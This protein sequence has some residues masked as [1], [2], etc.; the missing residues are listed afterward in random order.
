ME[1]SPGGDMQ[2]TSGVFLIA[3]GLVAWLYDERLR[4]LKAWDRPRWTL[5][6][7]TRLAFS[8]LRRIAVVAGWLLLLRASAAAAATLGVVLLGAWARIRW[9]RTDAYAA[10]RLR[11]DLAAE[12]RAHPELEDR[13]LLVRLVVSRHPEWGAELAEQM[14]TDHPSLPDLARMLNRM[15]EGWSALD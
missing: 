10:R 11:A 8:T 14:V 3:A 9:T 7:T 12:R 4:T 13:E 2:A 6:R 1:V 15:R 5:D